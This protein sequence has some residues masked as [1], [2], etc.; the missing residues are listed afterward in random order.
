MALRCKFGYHTWKGCK[1][2]ECG[3]TRNEL[4]E[5]TR[6]SDFCNCSRCGASRS[7]I[8]KTVVAARH[9]LKSP[10]NKASERDRCFRCTSYHPAGGYYGIWLIDGDSGST[11]TFEIEKVL[12]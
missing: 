5:W 11:A 7:L 10:L 9:S 1:C 2:S 3:K 8:G 4:H 12:D 6:D